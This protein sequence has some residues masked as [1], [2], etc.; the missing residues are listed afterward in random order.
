MTNRIILDDFYSLW[1]DREFC[2]LYFEKEKGLNEKTGK[3]EFERD[4]WYY[5]NS[6]LALS[7]YLLK[8]AANSSS[9]Q[10]VLSR[11]NQVEEKITSI[12]K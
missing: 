7:N 6:R 3:T 5:P 2:T 8:S 10:E 1:C 12:C 4:Q 9:V 11:I